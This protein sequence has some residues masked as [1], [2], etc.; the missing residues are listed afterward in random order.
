MSQR[1]SV[2]KPRIQWTV[3]AYLSYVQ[4]PL[5]AR[6]VAKAEAR[7]GFRLPRAYVEA[8]REQNGGYL[9]YSL[10][11]PE[12]ADELWGIGARF[13]S[14]LEGSIAERCAEDTDVW[15][16]RDAHRLV[17]FAGDG[18]WYLCFDGR[19]G[20]GEPSITFVDLECEHSRRVARTFDELVAKTRAVEDDHGLGLITDLAIEEVAAKLGK[21][22]RLKIVDQGDFDHGYRTLHGRAR[23]GAQLWITPNEAPRGFARK[24]EPDY[25]T[26]IKRMRGTALRWPERADLT[27]LV[28]LSD[29]DVDTVIV[30]CA[31]AG[32]A[33]RVF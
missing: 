25:A 21:S 1:A 9:R 32:L 19:G 22:L 8:L 13:P 4:A 10:S 11:A 16:P 20:R 28:S 3:P 15:M 27:S 31:R 6:A 24:N 23:S 26:L 12:E 7:F 30:A 2:A 5:T 18:H 17:P 14:I 29:F 33:V